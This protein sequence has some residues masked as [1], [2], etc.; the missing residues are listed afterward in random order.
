M[1]TFNRAGFIG[2][3]LESLARQTRKPDE[4]I[5]VDDQST[6]GTARLV[7]QHPFSERIRYHCQPVRGGAAVARNTG[8][9]MATGTVI[10]FLDSDDLLEPGY[11]EAALEV[12]DADQA[13]ALYCCDSRMIGPLGESLGESTWTTVQCEIKGRRIS[14]GLRPLTDIL[15][16]STP[17]P[18]LAIRRSVY[19]ELGGLN[20]DL[21]PLDD[22][23][24]QLRVAGRGLG[25]YYDHEPRA[26]YR[27]HGTNE[28]GAG[29]SVRVGSQKLRCLELTRQRYPEVAALGRRYVRRRGEVRRE[30]SI[31]LLRD[32]RLVEGIVG[33]AR[34]LGEDPAGLRDLARIASRKVGRFR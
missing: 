22:Y 5:V 24:L 34:S 27:V 3:A 21:F 4:V 31:S 26:R 20:Q 33:L 23:D 29:N 25:V 2:D 19:R 18:G 13:V 15:L 10:V 14:S 17:F 7:R 32:G 28:S 30:L 9:E 8:V 16:F 6:D 12:L 1:P 11:G